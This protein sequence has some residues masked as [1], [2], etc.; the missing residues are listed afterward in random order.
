M[1]AIPTYLPPGLLA[2]SCLYTNKNIMLDRCSYA[3]KAGHS[4]LSKKKKSVTQG[5][6]VG[7]N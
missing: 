7:P 5:G 4:A 1:Y 6:G 2:T 3:E